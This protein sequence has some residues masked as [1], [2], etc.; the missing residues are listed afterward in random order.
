MTVQVLS[1]HAASTHQNCLP[2]VGTKPRPTIDSGGTSG[3]F[4]RSTAGG[5]NSTIEGTPSP[6]PYALLPNRDKNLDP[7]CFVEFYIT[8]DR[9]AVFADIG[10]NDSV[11]VGIDEGYE[12]SN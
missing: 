6:L 1:V 3:A 11:H 12:V 9:M 8:D 4:C 7:Q 10:P 2:A 5:Q